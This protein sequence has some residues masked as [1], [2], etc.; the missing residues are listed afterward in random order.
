MLL[1]S[2]RTFNRWEDFKDFYLLWKWKAEKRGTKY[3]CRTCFVGEWNISACELRKLVLVSEYRANTTS[4]LDCTS[5]KRTSVAWR[6][7]SGKANKLRGLSPRANYTDR[8][9]MGE[10]SQQN[11]TLFTLKYYKLLKFMTAVTRIKMLRST[12][13][14]ICRA[15]KY[16]LYNSNSC[17]CPERLRIYWKLNLITDVAHT[18]YFR[19][20]Q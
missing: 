6:E 12:T 4:F 20:T 14:W 16:V 10:R 19:I 11:P 9:S 7:E 13:L 17:I 2:V 3:K 5:L 1:Y 15:V 8:A 18:S